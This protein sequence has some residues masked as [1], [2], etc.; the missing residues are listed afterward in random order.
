MVDT[1]NCPDKNDEPVRLVF[2]V[3]ERVA[4][5]PYL[6]AV[7]SEAD[8]VTVVATVDELFPLMAREAFNGILLDVPT[9]VRATSAEKASL[10]DLLQVFPTLRVKWDPRSET[11]RALFYDRVPGPEAGLGSFVRQVCAHFSAR[12]IRLRDRISVHLNVMVSEIPSFSHEGVMRTVSLNL[13]HGGCFL[14]TS[15]PWPQGTRLWLRML[16]LADQAPIAV[17]V[18]WRKP[19]GVSPGIAGAGVRFL[20][21]TDGQRDEVVELCEHNRLA[22]VP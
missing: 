6:D 17:E 5:A 1:G 2:V 9:L 20:E 21:L 7:R 16:E 22:S 8:A 3:E 14:I 11:V 18:R 10:Y 13:S 4:V 19:W 12:I 15:D